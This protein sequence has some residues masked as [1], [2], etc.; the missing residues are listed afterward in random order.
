MTSENSS[1]FTVPYNK[2]TGDI[3]PSSRISFID[4]TDG[5]ESSPTPALSTI[6]PFG[7]SA[8]AASI[9]RRL[10]DLVQDY[11]WSNDW[12]LVNSSADIKPNLGAPVNLPVSLVPRPI[13][14]LSE[15]ALADT[16]LD[17]R[18]PTRNMYNNNST[19]PY[20]KA[21]ENNNSKTHS[22]ISTQPLTDQNNAHSSIIKTLPNATMDS[23]HPNPHQ[24]HGHAKRSTKKLTNGKSRGAP[25]AGPKSRPAFVLKLWNMVNDKDNSPYIQWTSDG[26]GF[27]VLSREPFEKVV[28]PKYFKHS[29]FSSFVR[30]L[31]MY[32]WHKVQD[33]TSGA[34]QSSDETWQFKSPNFIRG[35]EDLL[36]NIVRNKGSKGSDDEEDSEISKLFEE[37]E[38]IK[39]NQMAIAD[40]LNRIRKDN[41]MLW[42][43][44][45]ESRER[46]KA[47]T[48]TFEKI[49]RFLASL[50]TTTQGKFVN[51]SSNMPGGHKQPLLLLPNLSELTRN[52]PSTDSSNATLSAIE[53]L[54]TGSN[55]SPKD[56]RSSS[57]VSSNHH[58][59]SSIGSI[60][61]IRPIIT[62]TADTPK[63]TS[64]ISS[65]NNVLPYGIPTSTSSQANLGSPSIET[66][67]NNGASPISP[68]TQID[69]SIGEFIP[70]SPQLGPHNQ[71][72]VQPRINNNPLPMNAPVS[73]GSKMGL[74]LSQLPTLGSSN[75]MPSNLLSRPPVNDGRQQYAVP[76]S[77]DAS[78]LVPST[79][80]QGPLAGASSSST[81]AMSP[82]SQKLLT[83]TSDLDSLSRNIDLQGQSLQFVQDWVRKLAPAYDMDYV[84]TGDLGADVTGATP[85]QDAS[86]SLQQAIGSTTVPTP[87]TNI[88]ATAAAP[89]VPTPLAGDTFNVDDFLNANTEMLE[90]AAAGGPQGTGG[91]AGTPHGILEELDLETP[92]LKRQKLSDNSSGA[93]SLGY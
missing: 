66:I 63:S 36:D 72:A 74:T 7:N 25:A 82:L 84:P 69:N 65:P 56:N 57:G 89:E 88:A 3:S 79:I 24:S 64:S 6:S 48:E 40:E 83:S 33:V 28:L 54:I 91:F 78:N 71:V 53:E 38:F 41:G 19:F 27:Q 21:N 85:L 47:H 92:P 59:I 1:K 77:N 50:Y 67:S 8:E 49:L 23:N 17:T 34:M 29:N 13:Q 90:E 5:T 51:D 62:E 15:S 81:G 70:T 10:S 18:N 31:N 37:F 60:D 26:E 61:E 76:R 75:T 30:Q 73:S 11:D 9:H 12:S 22:R 14:P 43:E 39:S 93:G 86:G 87:S 44:C 45:Y 80:S 42:R 35:R 4:A 68:N 58:R 20:N 46:H 55:D 32:G 2:I 16:P 52:N